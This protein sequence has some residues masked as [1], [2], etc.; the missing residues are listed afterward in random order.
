M[1]ILLCGLAGSASLSLPIAAAA[2]SCGDAI[3]DEQRLN[4][5][6]TCSS[7]P[8]LK[9]EDQGSLDLNGHTISCSNSAYGVQL[10]GSHNVIQ[11]T[12]GDGGIENCRVGISAEGNGFHHIVDINITSTSE[13][14]ISLKSSYNVIETSSV[15]NNT[16]YGIYINSNSS[17]NRVLNT[18]VI[19]NG[20]QGIKING[21]SNLVRFS[22]VSSGETIGIA[23]NYHGD[24]SVVAQNIANDNGING[25][26]R[27]GSAYYNVIVGNT[28][29]YNTGNDL[30]DHTNNC[31]YDAIWT[32]NRFTDRN[33]DC[34][35]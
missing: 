13:K 27:K 6:L 8:A 3:R 32:N 35:D 23:I 28:A 19:G 22:E 20:E 14:G 10:L 17:Y 25:I 21:E 9:I 26:S 31:N 29:R 5:D 30:T 2:V 12:V 4:Q 7:Y 1:K 16:G 18:E 24:Y 33:Q 34:I 15:S 11:D